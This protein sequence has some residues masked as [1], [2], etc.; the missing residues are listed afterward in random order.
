MK[1]LFIYI[2]ELFSQGGVVI[3]KKKNNLYYRDNNKIKLNDIP[4]Q[5]KDLAEF[6]GVDKYIE[7]C[8]LFG[9][10]NIYV[11]Q[12]DT[13][14]HEVRNKDLVNDY[15][16]GLSFKELVK[17]YDLCETQV[18]KIVKRNMSA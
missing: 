11:L 1:R 14:Y 10:T 12:L 5:S 13:L 18:R 6:L 8:K 4:S 16:N 9:G 7:F 2:L 17:K 3:V 15:R